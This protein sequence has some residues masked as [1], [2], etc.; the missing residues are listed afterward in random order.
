M[1]IIKN[2]NSNYQLIDLEDGYKFEQIGNKVIK[3]PDANAKGVITK[4]NLN[5]DLYAEYVG[6]PGKG[7]FIVNGEI[8]DDW[9]MNHLDLNL[10]VKLTSY[11]HIGVFPEQELHWDYVTDKIK[12]ADR[13]IKVLNLFAYTGAA[14]INAAQ[15]GASEVVHVEA[16]KQLNTWAKENSELSN[17]S[18]KNIRYMQDDVLTFLKREIKRGNKYQVIIMDPPSFGRGPNKQIWKFEDNI[19]ELLNLCSQVL[20]NP[21]AV[22]ISTYTNG[23][24]KQKL[25]SRLEKFFP[26]GSVDTYNMFL[27]SSTKKTLYCG[28]GGVIDF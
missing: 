7:E 25:K 5:D 12:H 28:T 21:L 19:D 3:R 8:D 17:T 10:K 13:D 6:E 26:A 24:N 16:L 18:D 27:E 22:V 1:K 23:Y 2:R 14:S 4:K 11:K 15:A 9:I 20:E